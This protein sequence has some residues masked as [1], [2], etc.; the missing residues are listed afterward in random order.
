MASYLITGASRGLGLTLATLLA[1]RPES[2]VRSIVLAARSLSPALKV[3]IA[4]YSNRLHFVSLEVTS[5]DSVNAAVKEVEK[6][7]EPSGGLDILINNAGIMPF[8]PSGIAEAYAS[9]LWKSDER[10]ANFLSQDGSHAY[11]QREC[12]RHSASYYRVFTT[13]SPR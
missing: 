3:L 9:S 4:K 1:A 8:N 7:L 5:Q 2:Q 10:S 11:S 13:P 12:Q 6:L